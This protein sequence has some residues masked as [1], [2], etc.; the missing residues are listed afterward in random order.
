MFI[1]CE[2][3]PGK[4]K[5]EFAVQRTPAVRDAVHRPAL[6]GIFLQAAE[7]LPDLSY[8]VLPVFHHHG[9]AMSFPP[10][11]A[12]EAAAMSTSG[13]EASPSANSAV[14]LNAASSSRSSSPEKTQSSAG[15]SAEPGGNACLRR[16]FLENCMG[17]DAPEP[18]GIHACAAGFSRLGYPWPARTIDIERR[19][20]IPNSGLTLEHSVGGRIL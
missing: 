10:S 9:Q 7:R 6:S 2:P 15:R 8:Q 16:R 1:Y 4:Q 17:I 3:S 13:Q 5:G 14:R 11:R 12:A 18:E 20:L 19:V